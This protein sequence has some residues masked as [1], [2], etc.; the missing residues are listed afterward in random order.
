MQYMYALRLLW[1]M[2]L[3]MLPASWFMAERAVYYVL[4]LYTRYSQP[5]LNPRRISREPLLQ[6]TLWIALAV[7]LLMVAVG[8]YM[9]KRKTEKA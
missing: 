7:L 4:W 2:L 5:D 8:Y 9:S 1:K 6:N 3:A